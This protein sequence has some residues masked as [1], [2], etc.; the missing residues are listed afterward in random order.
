MSD[1][2]S[3]KII[4]P[5]Y[6]NNTIK[7]PKNIVTKLGLVSIQNN[8]CIKS[9]YDRIDQKLVLTSPDINST[10]I[11]ELSALTVQG[12][13]P[14]EFENNNHKTG[15]VSLFSTDDKRIRQ[16]FEKAE[17]AVLIVHNETENNQN[18]VWVSVYP[19]YEYVDR[20]VST[21][22]KQ[23]KNGEHNEKRTVN[24]ENFADIGL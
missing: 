23:F 4:T 19:R 18:P 20:F 11:D 13:K 15:K 9:F 5:I 16:A 2:A 24:S 8:I 6:S 3:Q 7:I 14:E 10:S 12:A 17:E 21:A 22:E 1:E